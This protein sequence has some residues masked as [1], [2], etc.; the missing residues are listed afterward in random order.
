MLGPNLTPGSELATWNEED[1]A[2]LMH[3][4]ITPSERHLS[5]IMPWKTYGSVMTDE[6]LK[7]VFLYLRSL[8][9]LATTTR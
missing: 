8:P 1:F 6:E 9:T 4:G 5:D 3:T 2:R 7:A